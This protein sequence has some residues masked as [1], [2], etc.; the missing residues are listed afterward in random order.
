[1]R[2]RDSVQLLSKVSIL[3]VVFLAGC[4]SPTAPPPPPPPSLA[5]TSNGNPSVTNCTASVKTGCL[6]T[7]TITDTTTNTVVSANIPASALSYTLSTLPVTGIHVYQLTING[8]DG[9]G[10]TVASPPATTTVTIP[11]N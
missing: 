4:K 8:V 10:K 2:Q 7:Y 1:M 9:N 5:W 11:V 6:T 3:A